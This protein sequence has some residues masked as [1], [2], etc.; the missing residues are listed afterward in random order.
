MKII[1]VSRLPAK[2]PGVVYCGWAFAGWRCSPLHNP[3]LKDRRGQRRDGTH[4]EVITKYR[5]YLLERIEA[6]DRKILDALDSLTEDSVLGCWC[7]PLPCHCEVIAEVW[8]NL[9]EK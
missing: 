1:N 7:A 2:C 4:A 3:F 6:G 9:K 8:Q 5:A